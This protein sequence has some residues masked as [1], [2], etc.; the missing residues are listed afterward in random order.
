M[1]HAPPAAAFVY[2][3]SLR[4][5]TCPAPCDADG[6]AALYLN[7]VDSCNLNENALLYPPFGYDDAPL[8]PAYRF[9]ETV[10]LKEAV[11]KHAISPSCSGL[12]M[13]YGQNKKAYEKSWVQMHAA[14]FVA[15][16]R[17]GSCLSA[18]GHDD[19][20]LALFTQTR[21]AMSQLVFNFSRISCVSLSSSS[22]V[23]AFSS[24]RKVRVNARLF[25]VGGIGAP[26]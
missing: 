11:R 15:R 7:S 6:H 16:G 18:W 25:L 1:L 10:W 9:L 2:F 14:F 24:G 12:Y 5:G 4:T 19:S 26:S 17:T 21:S 20:F 23:N 3:R 13:K 22:G 8:F